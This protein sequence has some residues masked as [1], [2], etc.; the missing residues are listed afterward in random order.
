[1]M[2]TSLDDFEEKSSSKQLMVL[3]GAAVVLIGL[4][5]HYIFA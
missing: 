1:M 5:I 3:G 2:K 4:C